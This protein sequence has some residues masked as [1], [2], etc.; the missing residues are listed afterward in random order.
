MGVSPT[1]HPG[2]RRTSFEQLGQS[3]PNGGSRMVT[4][5]LDFADVQDLNTIDL[6]PSKMVGSI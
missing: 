6:E 3:T 5:T 4:L 2:S 1:T